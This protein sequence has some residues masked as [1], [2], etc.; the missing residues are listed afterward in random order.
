MADDEALTRAAVPVTTV[1]AWRAEVAGDAVVVLELGIEGD[2]LPPLLVPIDAVAGL[3][4]VLLQAAGADTGLAA[5]PA[6]AGAGAEPLPELP[7]G[8]PWATLVAADRVQADQLARATLPTGPGAYAWFRGGVPIHLGRAVG[9]RGLRA[10]VGGDALRGDADLTRS[11]FRAAVAEHLGFGLDAEGGLAHL[12]PDDVARLDA[13][14]D[15]CAVAWIRTATTT[16][17]T[18]LEATLRT[19]HDP[20]LDALG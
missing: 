12:D 8:S 7:T 5:G 20:A 9:K 17:A 14:I 3:A 11:P 13:W 15:G 10:R 1:E 16:Q 18:H 4:A 6:A 19:V 2:V